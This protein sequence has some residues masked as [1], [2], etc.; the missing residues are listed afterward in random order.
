[1]ALNEMLEDLVTAMTEYASREDTK[2]VLDERVL[3]PCMD[4]LW[5]K[6]LWAVRVLT[7]L[8]VLQTLLVLC[9]TVLLFRRR[10]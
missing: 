8:V 1:M 5:S 3:R 7:V 9:S 10:Q 6:S 4:Y 2:R